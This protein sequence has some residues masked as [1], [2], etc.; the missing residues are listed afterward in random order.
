MRFQLRSHCRVLLLVL[1]SMLYASILSAQDAPTIVTQPQSQTVFLPTNVTFSVEA[2]GTGP[3]YYQWYSGTTLLTSQTNTDYHMYWVNDYQNGTQLYVVVTNAYGSV[4]S[5]VA[6]LTIYYMP[7]LSVY[8][9]SSAVGVG[10]NVAFDGH[11]GGTGPLTNQ[12]YFNGTLLTNNAHISITEQPE[13]GTGCP[14]NDDCT[15]SYMVVSNI[16]TQDA[17]TY[18][19]VTSSPYG[20]ATSSPTVLD[21]GYAPCIFQSFGRQT[22]ILGGTTTLTVTATG[23][24]P[25]SY[26]WHYGTRQITN[27]DRH[28]G[29]D[30]ASMT[31]SN[32]QSA[33]AGTYSVYVVNPFGNAATTNTLSIILPPSFATQPISRSVPLGLSTMFSNNIAGTPPFKFQWTFNGTNISSA[34]STFYTIPSVAQ[35]NVGTYNLVVSNAAGTVTSSNAVLTIGPVAAWGRNSEN[36]CLPPPD[37]TARG[38]LSGSSSAS[39]ILQ[40]D[41]TVVHWGTNIGYSLS[42]TNAAAISTA[43]DGTEGGVIVRNDGTVETWGLKLSPPS[44]NSNIVAA[45]Y[46]S[47]TVIYLRRDGTVFDAPTG[48]LSGR[49]IPPGLTKVVAISGSVSQTMALR[50]DGTVVVWP[51]GGNPATNVPPWLTNV[52]AI[53]SG[54]GICL[55]L[56]SDGRIVAWGNGSSAPTNLPGVLTA[57]PTNANPPV[58]A[59]IAAGG[60]TPNVSHCLALLTNGTVVSWGSN[61]AGE[62]NSLPGLTNVV[63]IAAGVYHNVA[64]VGDGSPVFLQQPIGGDLP[65]LRDY[66]I[67]ARV[68]GRSPLAYQ[69]TRNGT[70]INGAT[71]ATLALPKFAFT[72]AGTYQLIVSNTIGTATSLPT[73]LRGIECRPF[74]SIQPANRTNSVVVGSAPYLHPVALCKFQRPSRWPGLAKYRGCDKRRFCH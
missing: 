69:W 43:Q 47:G 24:S 58:V 27:D 44:N 70:N 32:L 31:I 48:F 67:N 33:D 2:T 1:M 30:T 59:A 12:W 19:L 4:T 28:F 29:C 21:V 20:T 16:D 6:T 15:L 39:Y 72:N 5:S 7:N 66:T 68:V 8:G 37:L 36:Q 26:F 14:A 38:A 9:P 13:T 50:S 63:A 65:V 45:A 57:S 71:S 42:P 62:G 73:P 61:V 51:T 23:T 17:G 34:I 74:L 64:L 11:V 10:T 53:A 46:G 3:L 54:N 41:G 25:F 18:W 49:S 60:T 40:P 35:T 56:K 55:A 22:N 52:V